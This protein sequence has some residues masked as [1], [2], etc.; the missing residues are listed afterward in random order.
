MIILEELPLA[1]AV[2]DFM[3]NE[4]G[5][6]GQIGGE[7]RTFWAGHTEDGFRVEV[8]AFGTGAHGVGHC[9]AVHVL[10]LP[11]DEWRKDPFAAVCFDNFSAADVVGPV[12][13]LYE[14]IGHDFRD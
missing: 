8:F 11:D 10:D 7:P 3:D 2:T 14:D 5:R 12:F 6:A 13:A 1:E 4:L 9:L